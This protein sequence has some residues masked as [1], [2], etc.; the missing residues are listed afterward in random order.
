MRT[1]QIDPRCIKLED[2]PVTIFYLRDASGNIMA[3]YKQYIEIIDIPTQ[4]AE[5]RL[6]V[7]EWNMYGSSRLGVLSK[8]ELIA[9]RIGVWNGSAFVPNNPA[10]YTINGLP[11]TDVFDEQVGYKTYE[12]SNHLGNV[13]ATITDRK[14]PNVSG[15]SFTY[16]NPQITTITDYYPFGMQIAER[17]WVASSSS[18]RF[19][20]NGQEKENEVAGDGDYLS[21]T[22]RIHD[23][24]LGRFLSVDPLSKDYPWYSPY[25]FGGDNPIK[26]V[27]LEGLEESVNLNFT[28][29]FKL[30][31]P[32]KK[33]SQN[34]QLFSWS[35]GIGLGYTNRF[36]NVQPALNIAWN[37]YNGGLGANS[38]G[39]ATKYMD[40]AITPSIT[41]GNGRSDTRLIDFLHHNIPSG[42]ASDYKNSVTVGS[43]FIFNNKGRN[44]RV[45]SLSGRIGDFSLHTYNDFFPFIGDLR[46]RGQSGG[47]QVSYFAA[48]KRYF[49]FYEVFTSQ[50]DVTQETSKNG[51]AKQTPIQK[52]FNQG[53]FA[54]GVEF[55][56]GFQQQG[57]NAGYT[58]MAGRI[59]GGLLKGQNGIHTAI[60]FHHIPS[61]VPTRFFVGGGRSQNADLR[62]LWKK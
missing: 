51:I 27:D 47:G 17:S 21:F 53:I 58:I 46:D 52:L 9:S 33:S 41:Y 35:G 28:A 5:E 24:R 61:S 29:I 16:F 43:N 18:Y 34:K 2:K 44:Q 36:G 54:G 6:A 12:L 1:Q 60:N 15:T 13:L 57:F 11:V 3:T 55:S 45:G 40:L 38:K 62:N 59:G 42:V 8:E 25:Q 56:S 7:E 31:E 37:V 23:A 49:L 14:V 50:T 30:A 26:S 4:A 19:G 22:Y 32:K 39:D 48:N 20:F 10:T